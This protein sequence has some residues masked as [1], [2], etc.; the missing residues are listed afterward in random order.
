MELCPHGCY[1]RCEHGPQPVSYLLQQTIRVYGYELQVGSKT[2]VVN[3]V[4]L[5]GVESPWGI[6]PAGQWSMLLS[7][8]GTLECWSEPEP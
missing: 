8:D 2:G 7:P 1:W 6:V 5:D 4:L 3:A